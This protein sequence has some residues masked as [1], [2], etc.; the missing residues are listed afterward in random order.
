M[1][2]SSVAAIVGQ[3]GKIV[4]INGPS[5]IEVTVKQP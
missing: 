5:T 2:R 4:H 3:D 1:V